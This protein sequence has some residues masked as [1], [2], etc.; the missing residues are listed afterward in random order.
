MIFEEAMGRLI[1]AVGQLATTCLPGLKIERADEPYYVRDAWRK[2]DKI[3]HADNNGVYVYVSTQQKILYIGKGEYVGGGGIGNRAC[4]HL[5]SA[6]LGGE[7]LFNYHRWKEDASVSQETQIMIASGNFYIHTIKVSPN[8]Y[9]SVVEVLLQ[10]I[11]S[12]GHDKRFP[13]L[14]KRIG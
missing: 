7:T 8:V 4:G 9:C 12:E 2:P 11:F 5:G 3:P 10:S 14:N 1:G 13:E 6:E